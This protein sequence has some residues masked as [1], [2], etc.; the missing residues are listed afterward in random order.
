[1]VRTRSQEAL[2]E[3]LKAEYEALDPPQNNVLLED[4]YLNLSFMLLDDADA[5]KLLQTPDLLKKL[6]LRLLD[7]DD[8]ER[9]LVSK[10]YSIAS[11]FACNAIVQSSCSVDTGNVTIDGLNDQEVKET[12]I[13]LA[14]LNREE[15]CEFMITKSQNLLDELNQVAQKVEQ[16]NSPP[17]LLVA[18]KKEV[19]SVLGEEYFETLRT[20]QK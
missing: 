5:K 1:M 13:Y 7:D 17:M 4:I 14:S 11:E 15:L 10:L 19:E 12:K 20:L 8:F 16:T 2:K 9:F 18:T 3:K 6:L